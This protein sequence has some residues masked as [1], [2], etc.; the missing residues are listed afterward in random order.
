[1]RR[2]PRWDRKVHWQCVARG[3]SPAQACAPSERPHCGKR[4]RGTRPRQYHCSWCGG[5]PNS[6]ATPRDRAHAPAL[7]GCPADALGR[8]AHAKIPH[9]ADLDVRI[10]D[11]DPVIGTI[12]AA[13][14]K[15]RWRGQSRMRNRSRFCSTKRLSR[16]PALTTCRVGIAGAEAAGGFSCG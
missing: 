5:Q 10:V 13:M 15:S 16:R 1:V 14:R 12:G 9:P 3:G 7:R 8:L 4:T 11:I 6:A 2:P